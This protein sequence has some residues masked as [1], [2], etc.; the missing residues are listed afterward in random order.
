MLRLNE[1]A[2]PLGAT[3]ED[4][5]ACAAKELHISPSQIRTLEIWRES[6]DSRKK[7]NIKMIYAFNLE[8]DTD[9]ARIAASF[10]SSKVSVCEK[11]RYE[12]P[13]NR[14]RSALRP[15]VVGFGPAGMFA[16]L[17]LAEAGLA[18]IVLERGQDVDTRTADVQRFWTARFLDPSSNVQFGEGGAGTFSDGKLTTGIKDPRCRYVL[19][20]FCRFGAPEEILWSAHPHIGTDRL[21]GVVR[22]M[23]REIIRLGGEVR[24]GCCLNDLYV[25]NGFIQGISYQS[26]AG[27]IDLEADSLLLCIGHSARDT[28]EM[29][30]RQG[31]TM[32]KKAFSVGIRIEHPQEMINKALYGP[33]WNDPRLGAA[34]YKFANHPLHGRGGYTFCMCPGGTVVCASSEPDRVVVNGMSEYARDKENANAAILVGV[35]PEHI[36]SRHPLAGI[37]LQRQIEDAAFRFGGRDY[38]APAQLVGDF[39]AGRPSV[40]TGAVHPSCT[41]GVTPGDIR[42]VL[43]QPVTDGIASAIAAFDK[44]LP[45]FAMAD[46]VLTAPE[47]RSSSPVRI[48][49]D[50]CRQSSVKGIFPCGEGAGYAGGIVSAAVDG[51][52][53][54]EAVLL[55]EPDDC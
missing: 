9:E 23:R 50:E 4:M 52:K 44:K 19:E 12:M 13:E 15:V 40:K 41:T 6:V 42:N 2:L 55:D 24:F 1:V 43:P 47:S 39:F 21:K 22:E 35:E 28:V 48:V 17:L 10:P 20:T 54:A 7:H 27:S 37:A 29:L 45:G 49:R 18:P 32:E 11:Y 34:N 5:I 51:M 25:A 33:F 8:T 31:L 16:S 38:T 36:G 46:A 30:Y 3:R 14:R 53:G 26:P